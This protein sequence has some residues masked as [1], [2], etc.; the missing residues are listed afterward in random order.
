M[1][2]PTD[3]ES[4][5]YQLETP[6]GEVCYVGQTTHPE[7]RLKAHRLKWPEVTMRVICYVPRHQVDAV[8]S[9]AIRA[10]IESGAILRNRYVPYPAFSVPPLRG[11]SCPL[12]TPSY[13]H[14]TA[15]QG[16]SW[17]MP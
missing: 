7:R 5:I 1:T 4:A 12:A 16:R 3:W 11:W 6:A 15:M 8:E 14:L 9:H 2:R 17:S 10:A 13:E